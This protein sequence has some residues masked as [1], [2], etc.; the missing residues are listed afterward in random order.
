MGKGISQGIEFTFIEWDP[1]R[2]A[3]HKPR[4]ASLSHEY[5][6]ASKLIKSKRKEKNLSTS[7]YIM[8][9]NILKFR[10]GNKSTEIK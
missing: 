3:N 7:M 9:M 2:K 4:R 1:M 5:A 6:H 10:F 8:I